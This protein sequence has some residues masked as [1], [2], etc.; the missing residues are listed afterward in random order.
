MHPLAFYLFPVSFVAMIAALLLQLL[1]GASAQGSPFNN[2]PGV[3]IWCGKAYKEGAPNFHPGG[4]LNP[5]A[6][7]GPT[8]QLKLDMRIYPRYNYYLA[9]EKNASFIIDTPVSYARGVNYKNETFTEESPTEKVPLTEL[10]IELRTRQTNIILVKWVKIP[11]NA[12][13]F[14][15]T[16]DLSSLEAASHPWT[17]SAIANSPDAIQTFYGGSEITILPERKDGGSVARIDRLHGGIEVKS[18]ITKDV[19]KPVFPYSFYTSWDWI[20]STINNASATKNLATF[21]SQGYNLIHPVPPGGNDPF[22][23]EVFEEFLKVCD[24]LELYVM[25]DMRHTYKNNT[26]ITTQLSRL[27]HHPSLLLYYT[28]DEPDGWCDPLDATSTSYNHIRTID[29][30]HPV[31]L[32]LNCANFHFQEYTSGADIILEDAYPIAVDTAFSSVYNTNCNETYGD[33]GCDNCHANDPAFP[34]YVSNPFLDIAERTQSMYKFQEWIA[35]SLAPGQERKPVWGVP[36]AFFDEGSFWKRFPTA[37]EEAVMGVLRINHGAKGVVAWIYPTSPEIEE[38]T[39]SLA[40][41]VTSDEVTRVLLGA[42]PVQLES[43]EPLVDAAVWERD[44]EVLISLVHVGYKGGAS[45]E[46]AVEGV[47]G[48]ESIWGAGGWSAEGGK[49]KKGGI[50]GLEISILK[51]KKA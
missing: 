15:V 18:S 23:P 27:Q 42:S 1:L 37:Q 39:S 7:A 10:K 50:E 13:G 43:S 51:G 41:V 24:D 2:P 35:G 12:N 16:F 20:S 5:P 31:S 49:L 47:E 6:A 33:C 36:Q 40:K 19:W 45:A 30:Y 46:V 28:A 14:E 25:Y 9:G 29:P 11:V 4:W 22:D 34:A 3:D 44:G 21:R 32:V 17:I 8:D 48:L 26:S 38:V